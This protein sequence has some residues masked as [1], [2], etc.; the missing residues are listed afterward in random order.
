MYWE[1]F[2]AALLLLVFRLLTGSWP[3]MTV[4]DTLSKKY[5]PIPEAFPL[6]FLIWLLLGSGLVAIGAA[7]CASLFP[8]R[9]NRIIPV[10]A[11]C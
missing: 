3:F 10:T 8:Q 5:I 11:V 7:A 4:E 9:L 6:Q 1:T 2:L